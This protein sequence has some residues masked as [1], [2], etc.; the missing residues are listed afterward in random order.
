MRLHN[1]IFLYLSQSRLFWKLR[2]ALARAGFRSHREFFSLK[3]RI[4][5]HGI[6]TKTFGSLVMQTLPDLFLGILVATALQASNPFFEPILCYF[7]VTIPEDGEYGTLLAAVVGVG[8]LF[9]GLYYAAASAIAGTAYSQAPNNIRNLLA[10]ERRGN[11][12][13][14]FLASVTFLAMALLAFRTAGYPPIALAVPVFIFASG[15]SIIAFVRLG[16]QAFDLFDPT[17]LSGYLFENLQQNSLQMVAGAYRWSDPSFQS[18]AHQSARSALDTLST[19]RDMTENSI[20]LNGWPFSILCQNIIHFLIWYEPTKRKIPTESLWYSQL[21]KHPDWYRADDSTTSL[22]HQM[23]TSLPPKVVCNPNWVED[24]LMPIVYRCISLNLK[25]HRFDVV[26]H[27]LRYVDAY[28]QQLSKEHQVQAALKI[29]SDVSNACADFIFTP[30]PEDG[31]DESLEQIAIVDTIA[32]MPISILLA[33]L[34]AIENLN[35]GSILNEVSKINWH[36]ERH[37]YVAN[38]PAYTLAQ[39][40]WLFSKINFEIRSEGH[41]IS[42]DWYVGELVI[43]TVSEKTKEAVTSLF[44]DVHVLYE[45]WLKKGDENKLEWV[46]GALLAREEEY[47]HKV[48]AH[49]SKLQSL[50]NELSGSR[51]IDGLPWPELNFDELG[52]RHDKRKKDILKRMSIK[53][54]TLGVATRPDSYP[55]F[56]GKFLHTTGEALITALYENDADLVQE[57]FKPFLAGALLQYDRL[58]PKDGLVDLNSQI[59]FK[60]AA[61]PLMDL[62]DLSG[63][64]YFYAEYHNNPALLE[65][66]TSGWDAC[67]NKSGQEG[68]P[69]IIPVLAASVSLSEGSFEIAHRSILRTRWSQLLF[70]RTRDL[71][72]KEVYRGQ[73]M[74]SS[75]TV[76]IHDSA[77]VRVFAG[78]QYSS[79]YDGIDIFL[80]KFLRQ[81]D[82]GKVVDFGGRMHRN[83]QDAIE[84]DERDYENAFGGDTNED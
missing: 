2:A 53:A 7:N 33:Y 24:E 77:L 23:G 81:R 17:S 67:I 36:T 42:P 70:Y 22:I 13:M 56:S 31:K 11:V 50:W 62:M 40:Q 47:E 37:I 41:R 78:D 15:I 72:R 8:G 60:I 6:E 46:S 63:Y 84:R 80:F 73:H 38:L 69:S 66:V 34:S 10:H 76:A 12:Y 32:A 82:D 57:L 29:V 58:I 35:R 39:L 4:R 64:A 68:R 79:F 54:V 1:T 48:D 20:H 26:T 55:D 45:G 51:R 43:Q 61:A 75:D 21:Y 59:A 27:L 44:Q 9:I 74:M 30:M 65:P 18:H 25:Q 3:H 83:L 16:T 28:A 19:L 71:P 14:R 49:L 52:Q 5:K